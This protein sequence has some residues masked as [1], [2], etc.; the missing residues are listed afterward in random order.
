MAME[1]T[2]P[3]TRRRLTPW[4]LMWCLWGTLAF[5]GNSPAPVIAHH[6]LWV[7]LTA[8]VSSYTARPGDPVHA[9]LTE[10]VRSGGEV[11]LPVGTGID[12]VVHSVHKVGFGIRR[13]TATLQ[14]EFTRATPLQGESVPISATVAEVENGREEINKHGVIE[15]VVSS[16]TPQGRITSRYKYLPTWNPYTDVGLIVFKA[17][18]PIFPEP[19]IYLPAGTDLR[20]NLTT[21]LS[22]LPRTA[23]QE[24]NIDTAERW[25]MERLARLLPQ[26]S[27]TVT[28]TEGDLTNLVFVGSREQI[29][30][31]FRH[32]G[33]NTSD[34]NSKR[35][36]MRNAYAF[37]N[38]SSYHQAPMRTFLLEGKPADMSFQKSF[39][40]YAKRDHLR[41]WEW[42]A[43]AGGQTVWLSSSTHDVGASLSLKY[44][45]FVHHIAPDI[46]EERRNVIRD[47]NVAGCVKAD[48]LVARPAVSSL[49]LNATGD[50]VRTDG[51][52]AVVELQDC[53][54]TI[55]GMVTATDTTPFK[56]GNKI[57][58]Y[59][60]RQVLTFRSDVW[61]ANMIYG[62][63]ELGSMT[64]TAMRHHTATTAAD[65]G[66]TVGG[67]VALAP[68]AAPAQSAI[69]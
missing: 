57:F 36:V 1:R 49:S 56:A 11:V 15:G 2:L 32:A 61:R 31:A 34:A 64:V 59:V 39:N 55:P 69:Y 28:L 35:A 53:Q 44:H 29:E 54:P 30:S 40:S 27:T 48:Y 37:L 45:R 20:L 21:D 17:A 41:I 25:E 65:S 3:G 14:L 16:N 12:G 5:G 38:D 6:P 50:V 10:E 63:Y 43:E 23:P 47:L 68:A 22:L 9:I 19:E 18:F 67:T 46:D 26:R 51:A 4:C 52:L 62:A 13:E 33:W 7:R 8:P 24:D 42:P 58:R 60:R 66:A